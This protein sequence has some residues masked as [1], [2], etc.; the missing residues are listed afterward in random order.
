LNIVALLKR[1]YEG[2]IFENFVAF[3]RA[4]CYMAVNF[5]LQFLKMG[6]REYVRFV[7]RELEKSH[8][9]PSH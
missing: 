8:F 9:V 4:M 1:E 3:E 6:Y 2:L 7:V 5:H